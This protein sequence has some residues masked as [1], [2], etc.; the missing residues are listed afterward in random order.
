MEAVILLS[1]AADT[2]TLGEIRAKLREIAH[3]RT[4][5]HT[6]TATNAELGTRIVVYPIEVFPIEFAN[7]ERRI[8]IHSN[9][10]GHS[11][12]LESATLLLIQ[13]TSALERAID[14][15][16]LPEAEPNL[17]LLPPRKK[18]PPL[19]SRDIGDLL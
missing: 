14:P 12:C 1:E 7:G 15:A 13:L 5:Q 8:V 11:Y 19:P 18:T 10:G 2:M 3:V 16:P 4:T 9:H 17:P 6:V